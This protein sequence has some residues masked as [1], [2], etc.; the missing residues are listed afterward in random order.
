MAT[1][2]ILHFGWGCD[3]SAILVN[4]LTLPKSRDFEL[5]NL[6]VLAAQTGNE[7][8]LIKQQNERHIFP[9]LR[10]HQVRVVQVAKSG[11]FLAD[12]YEVLDDS[13]S[14]TTCFIEGSF[15]L[16]QELLTA[17]TVP[18]YANKRRRCSSKFKGTVLDAW[19]RDEFGTT[20]IRSVYGYNADEQYRVDRALVYIKDNETLSYPLIQWNW[21]RCKTESYMAAFAGERFYRSACIMCP[22]S[23]ISGTRQE[24]M[25]KYRLHPEEG[26]LAA[27][28]EFVSICLN[29]R[30]TLYT[31]SR[32]VPDLLQE[33]NNHAALENLNERLRATDWSLYRVRRIYSS[34]VPFRSVQKL[35]T[36]SR[37]NCTVELAKQASQY[38]LPLVT[39]TG[40]SRLYL[41][42]RG[43]DGRDCE[44]MYVVAPATVQSKER[45]SF[46][47]RWAEAHQLTLDLGFK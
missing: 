29:P 3:S 4:W 20:P 37:E 28:I 47:K 13:R 7:S 34:R 9:L 5:E 27:F 30:Q 44:E 45:K 15:T 24:I 16:A 26:G 36:G 31:K 33:D 18:S 1:P 42:R 41:K 8:E 38:N 46:E 22:F 39:E 2:T 12:G 21:N 25:T 43:D 35:H 19:V 11:N 32:T 6:I 17:G 23:G 40:I 10:Q 14:P